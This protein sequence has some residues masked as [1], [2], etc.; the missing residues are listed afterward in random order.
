MD[1]VLAA[2]SGLFLMLPAFLPNSAAVLFGGGVPVDF[3]KSWR[4]KRILGDGKTWTGLVGGIA[5]G[6]AFG[7]LLLIIACPF[8]R[9][10]FWG[11]GGYPSNM[12]VV[13]VL[14]TGS[15]M[16]D[17]VGAFIKR[18]LGMQRG[19]KAPVLDQYDF[20]VGAMVLVLIIYPSWFMTHYIDGVSIIGLIAL[21]VVVPILHRSVN[22]IGFKMGKK[23]EP[24]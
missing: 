5:A 15:L 8:D 23:K 20:I 3:G 17:M 19:Q 6:T 14:A 12:G 18:R 21:L 10:N 2:V 22:I 11:F 1:L 7:L 9:T 24:W 4:G 13:L 16:G